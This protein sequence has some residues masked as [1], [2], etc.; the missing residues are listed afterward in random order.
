MSLTK[1][2]CK[3]VSSSVFHKY[4]VDLKIVHSFIN[5]LCGIKICSKT[6]IIEVVKIYV[7][8]L[9]YSVFSRQIVVRFSI[10]DLS[11]YRRLRNLLSLDNA[12]VRLALKS[13]KDFQF[14]VSLPDVSSFCVKRI[15]KELF[16]KISML[17]EDVLRLL[18]D[19]I[20]DKEDIA[21]SV[22]DGIVILAYFKDNVNCVIPRLK[23]NVQ[24]YTPPIDDGRLSKTIKQVLISAL[25]AKKHL[26]DGYIHYGNFPKIVRATVICTEDPAFMLHKG[27]CPYAM[28][29]ILQ[30]LMSMQSPHG[31]GSTITQQLVRNAFFSGETSVIRKTREIIMALIVENFYRL[32]KHDILE[33]YLNMVELGYG[34]FGF[35]NASVHY[36]GKQINQLTVVEVLTLSYILPRA[37][38][39]EDALIH[40]T[41][42]L[43]KNLKQHILRFLSVLVNKKV[44]SSIP[45]PLPIAGVDFCEPFGFLSFETPS[46]LEMVDYIVVHCSATLFGSDVGADT[47]RMMHLKRGFDDVGY[48]WIVKLDGEI[49]AG[50][51]DCL[52]GAHCQGYNHNSIGVCYIGGLDPD[53]K[54]ANTLTARQEQ[55]LKSLCCELKKK[56]PS[57]RIVGHNQVSNKSC[58]CFDVG[59]WVKQNSL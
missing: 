44:I 59:Q 43:Q 45:I 5:K 16:I 25:R 6:V 41:Q 49:E 31:G 34:V 39:F 13:T 17:A 4:G 29:L 9:Y 37:I 38:Y 26:T 7:K 52:Q 32:S 36:F 51:N 42:Q 28:G 11:V 48:H 50:R 22:S 57:A 54:P 47:L 33:I 19:M 46:K 8:Y 56:Y 15:N 20:P 23:F 1:F 18:P 12:D 2:I 40:K 58:P 24:G 30:A 10:T 3:F 14:D 21:K 35:D 53:G 55:S 27:V